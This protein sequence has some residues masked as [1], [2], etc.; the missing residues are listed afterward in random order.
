MM[1]EDGAK[2]PKRTGIW[3]DDRDLHVERLR[4]RTAGRV[5]KH[6]AA[7]QKVAAALGEHGT[8]SNEQINLILR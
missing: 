6:R 2:V 4:I 5:R 8:L 1:A 3:D 7:I